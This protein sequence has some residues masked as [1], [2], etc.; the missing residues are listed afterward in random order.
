MPTAGSFS[1]G[2]LG[3]TSSKHG[4][5]LRNTLTFQALPRVTGAFR[6]SGVGDRNRLFIESGYTNWDRSFDLRIDV[7]KENS[8]LPDLTIGLQDFIGTG[9][10]S[11]EYLVA[12]KTFLNK[13][14]LTA[15]LGWGRLSSNRVISSTG[16]RNS[17][18]SD[19]GGTLNYNRFFKGNVSSFG[20]VE[21]QTP[22]NSLRLKAE[23]S[24][25]DYTSDN[26]LSTY[27]IDNN[28][29]YGIEYDLN[30]TLN[31]SAY[32]LNESEVGLRFKISANPST[33]PGNFMEPVPQPF[34]SYPIP[35]IDLSKNY[36]EELKETLNQE[37]IVLVASSQSDN[38]QIIV[39]EQ[40]HYSS[41]TQAIGRA[42]RIMSRFIPIKYNKFT[43]VVAELGIPIVE[44]TIDRNEIASIVDAPNSELIALSMA[45]IK[46]AKSIYKN[47]NPNYNSKL[48]YDWSIFPYY[49]LHLFDP[50]NPFYYDIG[51]RLRARILPKPGL[52]ISGSLEKS[53]LSSFDDINR[54]SKGSLPSVRTNMKQYLNILDERIEHL[55]MSSYFKI[56][57]E[58]YGRITAGYLEPMFAGISSEILFS[59]INKNYALGAEINT[60]KAREFRQLFGFREITG[61]PKVNGHLSAYFDT[62]FYYYKSQFDIGK[63]LAGDKGATLKLSR[64]FPNGWKVGG[65]FTLTDASFND[66]GEGSFDKGIFITIPYNSILPYQ[67]SGTVSETIKPIQGDGG[68]RLIVSD[69][70]YELVNDK[71]ITSLKRNWARIWR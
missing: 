14:R 41:N 9:M 44:I 60:V 6:Y 3:F 19:L 31:L 30:E 10:Y 4:P 21:Y 54:G 20:G 32:Y 43:V 8:Y 17:S 37:E 58:V 70:L 57:D 26:Y 63:Y 23:V 62:G 67:S 22:I 53:V 34:Y 47:S 7:L 25:D 45:E 69:R 51:P 39:I 2:E 29:N 12:S 42:L 28:Y 35:E 13:L 71:S 46:A 49:S 24:S 18:T 64:N 33:S 5:N 38:N 61:M 48:N 36:I 16:D 27:S 40:K 52:L 55:T 66:Y 65:F 50:D 11:S 56:Q 15:G 1:D 59:P 68:A